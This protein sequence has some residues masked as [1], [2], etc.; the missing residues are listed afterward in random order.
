LLKIINRILS[1]NSHFTALGAVKLEIS[2]VRRGIS[3]ISL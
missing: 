1:H 3:K 2:E